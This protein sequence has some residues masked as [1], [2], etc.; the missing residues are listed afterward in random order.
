[1]LY[2]PEAFEPL[3][4]E[5]WDERR[6]RAAIRAI[7][8]DTDAALR[9]P[10]L[11]WPADHWD[12][13]RATSPLKDVYC[14]AAGV[15]WALADLRERGHA[16]ST[17]D[18]GDLSRRVLERHRVR[19][20]L[21]GWNDLPEPRDSSLLGGAAGILLCAFRLAPDTELA[22]ELLGHVRAN[23]ANEA[24]EVMWGSP[25]TLIAAHLMFGWTRDERWRLAWEESADALLARRGADGLWTQR[26][27]GE[28]QRLLGP[29]HG[30]TGNVLS[31]LP[32][33]DGERGAALRREASEV[34]A[35]TAFVEDGRAN[36]PPVDRPNLES[37]DGS[38]RLQWCHGAP[39]VVWAAASYLE[40]E[41]LLAGAELTWRAGPHGLE[42]GPSI[43]H[44]TAG[45][46]YA[47]LAALERTGDEE[48]LSRARSF[49]VH[50]LGQV[51]R[52]RAERGRGRYSLWT[53]DLGVALYVADC[54]EARGAYPV[55]DPRTPGETRGAEHTFTSSARAASDRAPRSG[56]R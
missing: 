26:L 31:L 7:V 10:K 25:G 6:I 14:G 48:W 40:E 46:G 42:K 33:L 38:I 11:L 56:S 45:N 55:L 20:D 28:A 16:E 17:L 22:N 18:L 27:H 47:F 53:G 4:D 41:L 35:R 54:L 52:Q 39:G 34:L 23:A 32:L 29:I 9:G 43:C 51:E 3:T 44:G 5:E 1:M 36:W 49:A 8:A 2:R 30:M 21:A 13:W 19:P 12:R 15:L 50:A 37:H 24:D